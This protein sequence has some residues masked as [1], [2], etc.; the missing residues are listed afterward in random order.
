M[1]MES[2]RLS[3][4]LGAPVAHREREGRV[5][6]CADY[7]VD[8]QD[9]RLV[10]VLLDL[11]AEHRHAQALFAPERFAFEG[12]ELVTTAS[13][14]ELEMQLRNQHPEEPGLDATAMPPVVVGPFGYTVAPA[15]ATALVNS[16]LGRQMAQSRPQPDLDKHNETWHWFT[17]LQG[18]P[19]FDVT[20]MIG[21]LTDIV[22]DGVPLCCRELWVGEKPGEARALP[23]SR[24][25]N[26]DNDE[27]SIIVELSSNP[28]Y[29]KEAIVGA[30]KGD[31]SATT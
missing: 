3:G 20:R 12:D 18:L 9:G 6:T 15:M 1:P 7:L 27:T 30:M 4:Y 28:P 2:I 25:R 26:V 8:V 14:A 10:S 16:V 11:S 21:E 17:K 22:V 19:V 29:S 13:E 31:G 5:G 24:I 23:F